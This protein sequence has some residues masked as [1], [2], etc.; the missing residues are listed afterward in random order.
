MKTKEEL[1][2]KIND[3]QNQLKQ[4]EQ[5]EQEEL[6]FGK[7][8]IENIYQALND[9]D[10]TIRLEAYRALGFTEE[11][12]KDEDWYIRLQAYRVLGWTKEALKDEDGDIR[13]EAEQYFRVQKALERLKK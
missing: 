9:E 8:T 13:L 2:K 11:A 3:L 12:F 7:Y 1:Q 6:F 10:F 4:L 5:L